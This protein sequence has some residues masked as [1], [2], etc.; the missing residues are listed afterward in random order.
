[1]AINIHTITLG[2]MDN[3]IHHLIDSDSGEGL[4]IDPAWDADAILRVFDDHNASLTGILL[5]HSHGD[6]VS[7]VNDILARHDVPVYISRTELNLGL[8][9]LNNPTLIADGDTINFGR[10]TISVIE[11]PGH[12]VGSVCFYFDNQLIAG[13]TLFIDGCGRCDFR[14]SD[15]AKMW[16]SL[17]RLK[18]LPDDTTIHCGH[19]YGQKSVD[20]LGNQKRTNPYL[21][22]DDK[23]FFMDFRTHL[24][25][26]YR[27]I[28]FEPSSSREMVAIHARHTI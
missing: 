18:Q 9:Q 11:T 26:E 27:S 5:T 2:T 6:H 16:D 17:Q 12:T 8:F 13:D 3:L 14:E 22:I 20:N 24:Q 10:Q 4:A 7:A 21:L 19:D 15:V 25:A 23:A 1:M 28:P